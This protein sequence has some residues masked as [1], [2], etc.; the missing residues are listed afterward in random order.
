MD[1]LLRRADVELYMCL[2]LI[3]PDRELD[4]QHGQRVLLFGTPY[5]QQNW[6]RTHLQ[7]LSARRGLATYPPIVKVATRSRPSTL[8]RQLLPARQCWKSSHSE[9]ESSVEQV[10]YAFIRG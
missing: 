10:R 5:Y 2:Y 9:R 1:E 8:L 3:M 4:R 7:I 6:K